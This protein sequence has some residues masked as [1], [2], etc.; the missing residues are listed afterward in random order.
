VVANSNL[1]L[2]DVKMASKNAS[3]GA[4]YANMFETVFVR[5]A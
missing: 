2:L 4:Y 3:S 1:A 5:T